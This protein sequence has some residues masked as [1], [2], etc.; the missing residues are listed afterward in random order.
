MFL[1]TF[2]PDTT[3]IFSGKFLLKN[4]K[5]ISGISPDN[6]GYI[7]KGTDDLFNDIMEEHESKHNFLEVSDALNRTEN[8]PTTEV[9]PSVKIYRGKLMKIW[10]KLLTK[11]I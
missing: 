10:L 2:T 1:L 8:K 5:N 11:V 9:S 4:S 3:G 6:P 7:F